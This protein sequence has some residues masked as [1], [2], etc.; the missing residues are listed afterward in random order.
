[1]LNTIQRI[2]HSKGFGVHS[3]FAFNF[4]TNVI[5]SKHWYYAFIDLDY[6]LNA[7]NIDLHFKK[8]HHLSYRL[9][10]YFKPKSVLEIGSDIGINTL[11]I[12][13]SPEVELCDCI[14]KDDESISLAKKMLKEIDRSANFYGTIDTTRRYDSIFV[15]LY[16]E[17]IDIETLFEMSNLNAFWVVYGIKSR[18]SKRFWKS[19]VGDSR[20]SVTFDMN[21]IGIAILNKYYKKQN[22]LI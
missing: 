22:Y 9:I 14:E 18:S 21:G 1:M 20:V 7:N 3:P 6:I 10:Q 8:L 13:H 19:I 11:Y 5:Y 2:R 12:C 17:S 16:N 4:I 15:N